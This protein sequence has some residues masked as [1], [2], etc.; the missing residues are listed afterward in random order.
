MST[1]NPVSP[2]NLT[3]QPVVSSYEVHKEHHY[4][5]Q[6]H[7]MV[8]ATVA[9]GGQEKVLLD[10]GQQKFWAETRVALQTGQKLSLVVVETSPQIQLR[11]VEDRLGEY[12]LRALHL[13]GSKLELIPL[14]SQLAQENNPLRKNLSPASREVL[15]Q[16]LSLFSSGID[17]FNG[18]ELAQF[19]RR[20]GLSLEAELARGEAEKAAATLKAA[21]L[22]LG[23]A[24]NMDDELSETVNRLLQHLEMLQLCRARLIE[25][26][27]Y[28]VPLPFS[29]L[30]Q[31]Y[32]LAEERP[33]PRE[34]E[35]APCL[36][37]LYL[38]L[39]G[40][41]NMQIN[42]LYE[43]QGLYLRFIFDSPQTA[44]F[45][46]SFKKDLEESL[47]SVPLQ[48]VAFTAGAED[49]VQMLIKRILPAKKG[50]FDTRV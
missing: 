3:V 40:L 9:E 43:A 7:Q 38:K 16:L 48:G 45:V 49:P 18:R 42:F 26:G 37:S 36:L 50:V 20:L 30:E 24:E 47:S 17:G 22:G 15:A 33:E 46:S 21:L 25:Q 12:L 35:S 13:I 10:L 5:L 29:F 31:G 8:R 19:S 41:G 44:D 1:I 32:L 34:G 14:L 4:D 28:F 11:I 39:E 2:T 6:P 23:G 27:T